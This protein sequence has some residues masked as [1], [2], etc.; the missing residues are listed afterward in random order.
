MSANHYNNGHDKF[1]LF[2]K[3]AMF[4]NFFF[5]AKIRNLRNGQVVRLVSNHISFNTETLFKLIIEK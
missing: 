4:F 2:K 5:V 3:E 1:E